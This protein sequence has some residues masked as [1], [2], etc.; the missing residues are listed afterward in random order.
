MT[1]NYTQN[2]RENNYWIG[3]IS[4]RYLIG[5]DLH[6]TYETALKAVTPAK[7]QNFMKEMFKQGNQFEI[8]MNGFAAEQK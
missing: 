3:T 5:K 7:L 1:K 2:L 4:N 6:T 8:I